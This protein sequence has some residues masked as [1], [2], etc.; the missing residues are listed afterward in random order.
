MRACASG[1]FVS[2]SGVLLDHRYLHIDTKGF[3][4]Y[5]CGLARQAIIEVLREHG[6]E[7]LFLDDEWFTTRNNIAR[8][9][10]I[11]ITVAKVH[12]DSESAFFSDWE[13]WIVG[14]AGF[15]IVP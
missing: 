10:P 2:G 7:R 14:L 13:K 4:H 3:A 1:S 9:I 6:Q 12:S 5:S 15:K 8:V 11:Q